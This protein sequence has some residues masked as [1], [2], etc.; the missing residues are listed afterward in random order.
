MAA[1]YAKNQPAG[2]PNRIERV[3]IIGGCAGG[4]MGRHLT[5][6][7]L[8]IGKH[9]VTAITRPESTTALPDGLQ[10]LRVD[11]CNDDQT[12]LVAALR[13]QQ[14]LLIT[15]SVIAP[16]DT[17]VKLVRAAAEAGVPYVLPNWYGHDPSNEALCRDSML[18]VARD[19]IDAEAQ[20]LGRI[21]ILRL[22]CNFWYEFSLGGGPDRYGF[23]SQNRIFTIF[24]DGNSYR[25][26]STTSQL[27]FPTF[28]TRQSTYPVSAFRSGTWESAEKRWAEGQA[29]IQEGNWHAFTK[30]LYSRMFFT[31][32]DGVYEAKGLYNEM[33]DLPIE[34]LDEATS[35]GIRMGAAGEVPFSH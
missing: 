5:K 10:V 12:E 20:R 30:M 22:A 31:A 32:G 9:V 17:V 27:L 23:D 6:H 26:T 13:G 16:R 8:D 25:M 34:D 35:V 14:V 4:Q 28:A 33:L 19:Q 18:L 11:Y 29:A 15:M 21:S 1:R 24:G 2:F 7:L 3:A